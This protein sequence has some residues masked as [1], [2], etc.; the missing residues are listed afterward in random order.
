MLKGA[1]ED[2]VRALFT[3]GLLSFLDTLNVDRKRHIEGTPRYACHIS[4]EEEGAPDRNSAIPGRNNL[5]GPRILE[6]SEPLNVNWA[7][8]VPPPFAR[9]VFLQQRIANA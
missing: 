3:P 1:L 6:F 9:M 5:R 7:K 4:A 8:S 2:K